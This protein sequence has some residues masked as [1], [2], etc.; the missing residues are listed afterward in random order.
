MSSGK[1]IRYLASGVLA[2]CALTAHAGDAVELQVSQGANTATLGFSS[3]TDMF[4]FFNHSSE[5]TATLPWYDVHANSTASMNN[6]GIIFNF[7][8]TGN[9]DVISMNIPAINFDQSYTGDRDVS[10]RMLKDD[11]KKYYGF[12]QA[13]VASETPNSLVAGNPNSIQTQMASSQFE[14]GF[15]STA[16]S[17]ASPS[18]SASAGSAASSTQSNNLAGLGVRFG[19]YSQGDKN[20]QTATLPI[21][22]SWK[23]DENDER[24]HIYFSMPLTAG[25]VEKS[26]IYSAQFALGVGIP[27]NT[28]WAVTPSIGYGLTG[29]MDLLQA[30]QQANMSITSSYSIPLDDGYVVSIGNM[31][32]YFSTFKLKLRNYASD[33]NL[34]NF[35]FRNG[36]LLS[37][38]LPDLRVLG[39]GTTIELSAINTRFTGSAL[40]TESMNEWGVTLGTDKRA[41]G[42]KSFL[43]AG[44]S[45]ISARNA[46]GLSANVGYWF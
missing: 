9:G 29:S 22:Y 5:I 42:L 10:L 12:I 6:L 17:I 8:I 25:Q 38:P 35:I 20:I 34:K 1:A 27:I 43:R 40:Y 31:V 36:V 16:S 14:Y 44:I 37:V 19:R 32:G 11:I 24:R 30:S 18:S 21:S 26:K 7:S 4:Y 15:T 13:K 23:F 39:E 33:I 45:V 28:A 41:K 46:N 3:L 2:V